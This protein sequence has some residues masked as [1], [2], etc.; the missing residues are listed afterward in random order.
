[1]N[2]FGLHRSLLI[3]NGCSEC[4]H[5]VCNSFGYSWSFH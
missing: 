2:E 4:I 5:S 1:M 3:S